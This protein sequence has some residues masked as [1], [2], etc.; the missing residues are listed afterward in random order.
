VAV[1]TPGANSCL[2]LSM[3][4]FPSIFSSLCDAAMKAVHYLTILSKIGFVIAPRENH[5]TT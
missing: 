5:V 2:P 4:P 1:P 3:V